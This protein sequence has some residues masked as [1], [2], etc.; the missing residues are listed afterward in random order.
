LTLDTD[1]SSGPIYLS[2]FDITNFDK[3]ES[4][5]F[6]VKTEFSGITLDTTT[7]VGSSLQRA[8]TTGVGVSLTVS[9]I[10]FYPRN[11]GEVATYEFHIKPS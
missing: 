8:T 5:D 10:D 1:Y 4:E 9:T 7:S 6:T 3:G 2:L 11:E